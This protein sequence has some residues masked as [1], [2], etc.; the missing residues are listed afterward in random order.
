MVIDDDQHDGNECGQTLAVIDRFRGPEPRLM[1]ALAVAV[2]VLDVVTKQLMLDWIFATP[3]VVAISSFLNFAPVWN[4]GISFGMLAE[5]G[6]LVKMGLTALAFVVAGWFFWQ[7]RFFDRAQQLAGGFIA[8]GAIGNAI[9]RLRFGKVVDFI[10]VHV[11]SWHWPAFNVADAA[12]TI[13]V[14]FWI[15]SQFFGQGTDE[16]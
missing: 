2:L 13:G 11:Q 3:Q 15:Y 14:I 12:I 8:G 1:A 16:A 9:D 4:P 7:S 10:D 5:S 6:D